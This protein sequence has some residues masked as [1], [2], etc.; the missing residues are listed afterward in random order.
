[1]GKLNFNNAQKSNTFN[2]VPILTDYS[3]KLKVLSLF[4]HII[5]KLHAFLLCKTKDIL[6]NC[7]CPCNDIACMDWTI[8]DLIA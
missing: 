1:M 3:T 6:K 2:S 4:T 8:L 5:P 7:F